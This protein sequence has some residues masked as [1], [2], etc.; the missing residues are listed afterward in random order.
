MFA[1]AHAKD[2]NARQLFQVG[3]AVPGFAV[4]A[5]AAAIEGDGGKR[6]RRQDSPALVPKSVENSSSEELT[7]VLKS[8]QNTGTLGA[9]GQGWGSSIPA[10]TSLTSDF[11]GPGTIGAWSDAH[12]RRHRP[13]HCVRDADRRGQSSR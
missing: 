2:S 13:R 10:W 5:D 7:N 1:S 3:N 8:W 11:G 4:D 9:G 6:R 12:R